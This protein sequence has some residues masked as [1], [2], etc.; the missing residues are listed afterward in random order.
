ML[1]RVVRALGVL[2][3]FSVPGVAQAPK[4]VAPG[5][6]IYVLPGISVT[7]G[8]HAVSPLAVPFAFTRLTARNWLGTKGIGLDDALG[9][10]PGVLAQ[11][12][13]GSSD[14]RL[15]IRGF[16][17]RGAGDR[18]NAG[19]SRGVRVLLDGFPETEP[20][21]RTSFDGIDLASASGIEVIRSNASALFGN[22][23]GG[24]VSI[25]T[26]PDFDSR[27]GEAEVEAGGF[28]L[29]RAIGRAG[30][31]WGLSRLSGSIVRSEF[32]GWRAHSNSERTLV[33]LAMSAGLDQRTR[34]GLYAMGTN[35]QF[36]IPGPLTQA[37]VDSDPSQ[38]NATYQ[39][40]DERR[41]NR[42]GR[43]GASLE[44]EMGQLGT[45][46]AS[47]YVTPKFLQ[48]SER[49]TFRDFTRYHV[50]GNLG[51]SNAGSLGGSIRGRLQAGLD[52]AYQDGTI[53]FYS[54]TPE[55]TRGTELRDNKREG[56]NN[57]GVFLQTELQLGEQWG[58]SVG[59]RYDR[60]TY[61]SQSFIDPE[62]DAT[63]AFSRLTPKVGINFRVKPTQSFYVNLGGGIEVPAGNETDPASTFGQ[64]DPIT[65][66]NPLLDAIRSTT[67]EAGTKQVLTPTAG[68][69]SDVSY[70]VALYHTRVTNDIVPYRGGRFYF[71]AA[72]TYRS[73]AE[74][75]L[76]ARSRG[77]WSLSTALTYS[78]NTYHNYVVDSTHY[79]QPSGVAD[80]SGNRMIGLPDFLYDVTLAYAPAAFHGVRLQLGAR[81]ESKYF[82]D[83][84]NAVSVPAFTLFNAT[85]SLDDPVRLGA[86]LGVR[87][88]VTVNNLFDRRFIGS[89]FLNP[90]I[91]GGVPVAFEPGLPRT[92]I[93]G[94]ALGWR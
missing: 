38:A 12:R 20:D 19:T 56:A 30:T 44:H 91:L 32:D 3:A 85:I 88:Y 37:Q 43:F 26:L 71:T 76:T 40:R 81:G 51:Y 6:T 87:G 78:R 92:L 41:H 5:D 90:D 45:L 28:G 73:G 2:T 29:M 17:A 89:A 68:F 84:A 16:G 53:L 9:K 69:L 80:Y 72:K 74:L 8:R 33:N 58:F 22:A 46:T 34:L 36:R 75:A 67:F 7:A 61:Y 24:L 54:L 62:L 63:K 14:I 65:A 18:S 55:G 70:D 82:V 15:V 50:G 49:G 21:G 39:S 77:G 66:I 23:S 42:L 1:H 93:V 94:A 47:T 52:E 11:S 13:Y 59:G 35:N 27:Y 60:V 83:D 48:R 64:P 57:L 31:V 86:G 4:P 25:S 79:G 10:V